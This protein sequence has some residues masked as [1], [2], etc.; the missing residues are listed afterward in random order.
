MIPRPLRIALLLLAGLTVLWGSLAPSS[1]PPGPGL[2]DKAQHAAAYFGLTVIGA[3]AFPRR[4]TALAASLFAAGVGIEILQSMM[5]LGRQGDP[6]D[7]LA[8]TAGIAAG[9]ILTLAARR[10]IGDR[11]RAEGE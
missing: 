7:A 8:N 9:L 11:P 3:W 10:L 5:N 4:L 1:I 6:A 2:W